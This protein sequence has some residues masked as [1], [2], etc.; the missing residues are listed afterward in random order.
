M[1]LFWMSYRLPNSTE[2]QIKTAICQLKQDFIWSWN[3]LCVIW[4]Y[5]TN[6]KSAKKQNHVTTNLTVEEKN[7]L[8]HNTPNNQNLSLKNTIIIKVV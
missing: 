6:L 5:G 2:T 1:P 4:W 8:T 7:E 3:G